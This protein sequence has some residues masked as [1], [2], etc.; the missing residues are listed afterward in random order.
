MTGITGLVIIVVGGLIATGGQVIFQGWPWIIPVVGA[1]LIGWN[2]RGAYF[3]AGADWLQSRRHW[4]RVYELASIKYITKPGGFSVLLQDSQGGSAGGDLRDLQ[5]NPALWDLV[6]NGILHSVASRDVK[7]NLAARRH[8]P[9]PE[10]ISEKL[11]SD[12][13]RA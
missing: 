13:A 1:V 7:A 4:V 2:V 9:L 11:R 6:Y 8:L 10:E 3:A 5:S 12:N